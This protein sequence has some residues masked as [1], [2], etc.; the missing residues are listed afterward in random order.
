M[1]KA[2]L[3]I[4]NRSLVSKN[5]KMLKHEEQYKIEIIKLKAKL[6][7]ARRVAKLLKNLGCLCFKVLGLLTGN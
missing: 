3:K 4:E 6:S 2:S 7:E 1:K 5:E